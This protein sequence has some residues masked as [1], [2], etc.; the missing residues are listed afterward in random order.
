MMPKGFMAELGIV[1]IFFVAVG[2][3]NPV[4]G[5]V[6]AV[7]FFVVYPIFCTILLLRRKRLLVRLDGHG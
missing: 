1:A 5:I 4:A 6:L 2:I 7:W 3:S